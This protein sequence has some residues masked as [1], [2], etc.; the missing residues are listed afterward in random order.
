ML[1][2]FKVGDDVK[3]GAGSVVLKEVPPNC[4]VVGI[5]GTIVK[6]NGMSTTQDLNQVDLP[7]PIA[8]E[9]ECLRKRVMELE[10][11]LQTE[12]KIEA[13]CIDCAGS[14]NLEE[15]LMNVIREKNEKNQEKE[16][17]EDENL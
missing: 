14:L 17:S 2:P 8:V 16:G 10:K 3:I 15:T 13:G 4:T 11:I 1:G 12:H 6:R 5:P 7:D 9:I